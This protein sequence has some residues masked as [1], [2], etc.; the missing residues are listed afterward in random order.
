MSGN[1]TVLYSGGGKAEKVVAV[2]L[3]NDEVKSFTPSKVECYGGR[4][5]FVMISA[6]QVDIVIVK[7]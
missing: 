7:M 1:Y 5:M 6:K 4:L 2:I 3:R